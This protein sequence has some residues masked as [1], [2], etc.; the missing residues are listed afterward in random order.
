MEVKFADD[1]LIYAILRNAVKRALSSAAVIP[2]ETNLGHAIPEV[3]WPPAPEMPATGSEAPPL[4]FSPSPS[5]FRVQHPGRQMGLKLTTPSPS[6]AQPV[7][8]SASYPPDAPT[9]DFGP[10]DL[11]LQIWQIHNRY[12]LSPTKTGLMIVDQHVAHERILYEQALE[13]FEKQN[14]AP[15]QLLFPVL[16]ELSAEDFEMLTEF[17]PF[18]ERLGFIIKYFGQRT[19][20]IEAVPS[21]SRYANNMQDGKILLEIIDDF[22][23]GKREKLEIRDNVARSYAC[24]TAVRSGDRLSPATMQA[25]LAQLSQTKSPYFCPHGR[26]VMIQIPLEELDKKFGRT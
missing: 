19:M 25:L 14:P 15:Q 12:I 26:P 6:S 20:M 4:E 24:H 13:K 5:N 7:T 10:P 23:R 17:L 3:H 21:G 11:G 1:R 8:P 9:S 16:V 2:V 18:L 22:R